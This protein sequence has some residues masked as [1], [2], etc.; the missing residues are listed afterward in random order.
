M[1]E[2]VSVCVCVYMSACMHVCISV[3][4]PVY[5]YELMYVLNL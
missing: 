4:M 5:E 1:N 2:R 3:C